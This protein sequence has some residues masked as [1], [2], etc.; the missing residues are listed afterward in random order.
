MFTMDVRAKLTPTKNTFNA[1]IGPNVLR[2]QSSNKI[3]ASV[4]HNDKRWV[5]IDNWY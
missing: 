4:I 5:A 1:E 3:V 2:K